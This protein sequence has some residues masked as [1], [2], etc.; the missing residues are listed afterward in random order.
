MAQIVLPATCHGGA[1]GE[2]RPELTSPDFEGMINWV[3]GL[4]V[5]RGFG[6]HQ[7]KVLHQDQQKPATPQIQ[8]VGPARFPVKDLRFQTTPFIDSNGN[9]RFQSLQW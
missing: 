4:I 5:E 6:G 1:V 9:G 7:L 2:V 3:K 8:Y